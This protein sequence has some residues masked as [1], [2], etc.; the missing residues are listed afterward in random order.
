[1]AAYKR[2]VPFKTSKGRKNSFL[3]K[4][5]KCLNGY[6]LN[7]LEGKRVSFSDL[8]TEARGPGGSFSED[9]SGIFA[10][11]WVGLPSAESFSGKEKASSPFL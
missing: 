11:F 4:K 6:H 5:K 7:H 1:M 9:G 10:C 2:Q 3:Q 8:L